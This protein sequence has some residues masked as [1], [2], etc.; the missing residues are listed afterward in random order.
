MYPETLVFPWKTG[1]PSSASPHCHLAFLPLGLA[2]AS[3][4]PFVWDLSESSLLLV[5]KTTSHFMGK[6]LS[7]YSTQRCT[8]QILL[9]GKICYPGVK[10]AISRQPPALRASRVCLMCRE[11]PCRGSCP[12]RAAHIQWLRET[13]V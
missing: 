8:T 3:Q 11:Q 4:V 12:S 2:S 13:M 1:H 6:D 9:Q 7:P 5:K 10:S